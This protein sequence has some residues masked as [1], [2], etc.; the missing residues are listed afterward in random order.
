MKNYSTLYLDLDNTI[1]DFLKSENRAIKSVLELHKLPCDEDTARLYSFINLKWWEKFER[2]EIAK[3]EI[4]TGRFSEL[5][6]AINGKANPEDMSLDYF[7][8]LSC[9]HDL[10]DGALP[11]LKSLKDFGYTVCATTNGVSMTQHRRI[12]DSGID[13]FLDY[14]FV[15][16]DAGHQKPEREYFDYVVNNSPE[17]DR[18]KILII[19]DSQTSDILG[20]VNSGIDTCWYNPNGLKPVYNSRFEV[21]SLAEISD[22]LCKK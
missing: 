20:G 11:L 5:L 13:K 15:S 9:G 17:K 14:V 10:I 8:A 18:E 12:N 19:G 6:S 16:E 2:G 1:F 7:K 21:R 4:F 3:K 22:I